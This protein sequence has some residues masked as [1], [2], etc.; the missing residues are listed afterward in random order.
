MMSEIKRA[1]MTDSDRLEIGKD[2]YPALQIGQLAVDAR[3]EN[4]DIGAYLLSWCVGLAMETSGR[5]ACR[6]IVLDSEKNVVEFYRKFGFRMLKRQD[7]RT[8]PAMYIDILPT[9]KAER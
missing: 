7:K 2:F 1:L 8:H 3:C 9:L 6:F 5:I 4:N